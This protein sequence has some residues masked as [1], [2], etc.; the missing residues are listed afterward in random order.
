MRIRKL[1]HIIIVSVTVAVCSSCSSDDGKNTGPVMPNT[2]NCYVNFAISVSNGN[3][4][5]RATTPEGDEDGDGREA[6]FDRENTI[7]GITVILYKDATGIN[8]TANPTL[9][10]VRYF[11]VAE[12]ATGT[13]PYEITYT[14]GQQPLGK[15]N[16]D[17]SATYHVIVIANAPEVAASLTEG[18]ST[19]NDIRDVTLST[20]YVGNATMPAAT[21]NHFVMSSEKDNTINFSGVTYTNLDGTTY[22]PGNDM[23]YDLTTQPVVIERMSARI[24][25]WSKNSNGYKTST[26]NPAY[27]IPGYEYNVTSSTDKFVVT[28]IVPFNIVNGHATYGKEYLIKRVCTDIANVASTSSYLA[29]EKTSTWVIDPQTISKTA[30]TN[31]ELT[32]S[33]ASVYTLI[34]NGSQLED[35]TYNPYFHSIEAMHGSTAKST[36]DSKENVVVCYP[37]ENCLLPESKLYY[38]ATGVAIVGYYYVNGTGTG[39]R[40]VYLGYMSH[41]GDAESYNIQPYTTPLVTTDA[42]GGATAMKYGIVRNN[43]YRICINSIDSKGSMELKIKVK[44]WDTFTHSWIYM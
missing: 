22:T 44:K 13:D 2:G 19:L 24:D 1:L 15:H 17:L 32:S 3:A 35:V 43:I 9:D 8:T 27:T 6:G 26:E 39:T 21:C 41:Q 36:I 31:P 14:T 12:R 37:M 40:Y 4:T 11:T 10:L 16:L 20:V 34:G 33:L 38:H 30:A 42:M 5:M 28:G 25:F 18:T 23:Y 7:Q 29:D